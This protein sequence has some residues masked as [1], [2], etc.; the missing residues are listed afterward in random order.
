MCAYALA[1]VV[2]GEGLSKAGLC[3]PEELTALVATSVACGLLG[4]TLLLG[5]QVVLDGR[6][7]VLYDTVVLAELVEA[8]VCGFGCYLKPLGARFVL[9]VELS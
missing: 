9:N 3:I 6:R 7:R 8:H 5:A 4:G 2:G 1:K